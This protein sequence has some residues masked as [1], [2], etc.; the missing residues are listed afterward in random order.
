MPV[1]TH[2]FSD[3]SELYRKQTKL[4]SKC[5]VVKFE[6][7]ENARFFV[8]IAQQSHDRLE[9]GDASINSS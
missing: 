9:F 6:K 3:L 2:L 8:L 7:K 5:F 1:K 4:I